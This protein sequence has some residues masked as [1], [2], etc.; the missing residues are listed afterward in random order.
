MA[1]RCTP[2][3]A[4]CCQLRLDGQ[5]LEPLATGI[6]QAIP[7]IWVGHGRLGF[8]ATS[9]QRQE[10]GRDPECVA[11]EGLDHSV[12]TILIVD[13][14]IFDVVGVVGALSSGEQYWV[15]WTKKM[16]P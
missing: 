3:D 12:H 2:R 14:G 1:E 6:C 13:V 5:Q 7:Y 4:K 8:V 16:I 11:R 15:A 10:H 9:P